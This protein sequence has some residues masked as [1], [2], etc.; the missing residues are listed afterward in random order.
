VLFACPTGHSGGRNFL[1]CFAVK[2]I[3]Q[4]KYKF[5]RPSDWYHP[6]GQRPQSNLMSISHVLQAPL[7]R[8]FEMCFILVQDEEKR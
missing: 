3:P 5:F 2:K 6:G 7:L 8:K 1:V 4:R